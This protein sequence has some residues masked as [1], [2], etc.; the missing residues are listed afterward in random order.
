MPTRYPD[1]AAESHGKEKSDRTCLQGIR[2]ELQDLVLIPTRYKDE[3][4][5][6]HA[7]GT[8]D[9]T[10]LRRIRTGLQVL[11][12]SE[13]QIQHAYKVYCLTKETLQQIIK[14]VLFKQ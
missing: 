1:A 14:V 10:C 13:Q 3:A 2:K 11:T 5:G 9:R 6:S 4:A 8:P 12:G 7:F